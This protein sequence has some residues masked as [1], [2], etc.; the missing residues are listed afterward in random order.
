MYVLGINA[1]HPDASVALIKDGNLVWAAEEER[2]NRIKHSSGFP[3]Q[4]LV[5]CLQDNRLSPDKIDWVAISKDPYAQALQKILFS[6]RYRPGFK[7]FRDRARAFSKARAF[8]KDFFE[9]AAMTAKPSHPRFINVEHHLAHAASSFYFSGFK[10][11]AF[12]SID[13]MGDFSSAMWGTGS[14]TGLR[15]MDRVYFPHSA[16]FLYTAATQFLGFHQFGDE[17]KV[18]GLAAYGKP[19]F[20][21]A[22]RRMVCLKKNGKFELCLEYFIHQKG[23]AKVR[24]DGGVPEQDRL[25]SDKWA[26]VFGPPRPKDAP[27][28]ARDQDMAASLQAVLEEIYFHLLAHLYQKTR[29]EN[30]C[31]A[32]G[33]A[34]NSVANGKVLTKTPFKKIFIQPAAGDAGTAIGAAAYASAAAGKPV[35][36][37]ILEH[38]FFGPE[39]DEEEILRALSKHALKWKK[40]AE[41]EMLEKMAAALADKKIIGWFHGRMEF[42]PRALGHR[43]ILADPRDPKM[44]DL[45]N[46]R[47]KSRENFRPFAPAVVEE[48]A[49][50]YF[51]MGGQNSPFMLNVYPVKPGKEKVI[52]AVTHV[53]HTARV[54][55]V[56]KNQNERFWKL[57]MLFREQTGIP[58]LLNTSFNEKEP[59][60][61]SPEDAIRCFFK[62]KIDVLVL[63]N[64]YIQR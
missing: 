37:T 33:V 30:L 61:C 46:A 10:D 63:G 29:C 43:S 42:G 56:A 11:A 18:M 32:G 48:Y 40:L 59:I 2:F 47:I 62:T 16:G 1:Y 17:Y 39:A 21:E 64:Y 38:V 31:L 44:M 23:S 3:A 58:I 24:W 34:F 27:V 35:Q 5:R 12:L 19:V 6:M 50:E 4:A 57:L 13:G 53:D 26:Q 25:Y 41:K 52:P 54:Q 9:A 45:L 14:N 36:N 22:F 55:T 7:L 15:V 8:H 51:E 20:A 49:G 60:V 28:S